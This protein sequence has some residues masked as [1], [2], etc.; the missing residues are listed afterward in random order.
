MSDRW[1]DMESSPDEAPVDAPPDIRLAEVGFVFVR[2]ALV[3]LVVV[4]D[5]G[6]MFVVR[7]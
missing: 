7:C 2:R 4:S 1:A 5:I 3:V 6:S